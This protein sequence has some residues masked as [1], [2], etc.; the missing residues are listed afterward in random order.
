MNIYA[1]NATAL[2]ELT[3]YSYSWIVAFLVLPHVRPREAVLGELVERWLLGSGTEARPYDG[4]AWSTYY[5]MSSAYMPA[6]LIEV[7][8]TTTFSIMPCMLL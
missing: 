7:H 1:V 4:N 2:G 3:E 5:R 6:Y 8:C